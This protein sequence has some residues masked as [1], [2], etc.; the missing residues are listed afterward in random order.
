MEFKTLIYRDLSINGV[1]ILNVPTKV[2]DN[3]APAIT[4]GVSEKIKDLI[5]KASA[6]K[7]KEIDFSYKLGVW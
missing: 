4:K 5:F 2:V 6:L 1:K 3:R 7:V